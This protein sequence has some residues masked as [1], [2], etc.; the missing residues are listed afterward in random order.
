MR[1]SLD[2]PWPPATRCTYTPPNTPLAPHRTKRHRTIFIS[3]THLGTRGCKAELLAD[4]LFHNDCQTLYLVGDIV[5][6]WRLK[7]NWYWTPSHSAVLN[8]IL[9]KADEGTRIIYV[10]GNH[11]EVFRAYCG[12]NLAG[13]VLRPEAIHETADGKRLLVIH[14][15]HFDGVVTSARWLAHLGD[16]A[17]ELALMLNEVLNNVRRRLNL[18]YWSLSAY[19]K[20]KVKNAAA[21]ISDF[22][23]ALAREAKKRGLDG[24]V[25]GHIHH[26]ETK[27]I[28]RVL[29]CNDG[30]WVESCTALVEDARGRLQ[31]VHWTSLAA[32]QERIGEHVPARL[33]AA[34]AAA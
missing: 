29:Y 7:K 3:D 9:R 16:C 14:G 25:A 12:L 23:H 33:P 30:D 31:I 5:D 2:M 15:D 13:V 17:Y 19:L 26:A 4:F 6:G 24:V 10:P 18:P 32:Q 8:A 11:D 27:T 20:R 22:E 28:D 34:F 21:F 1:N